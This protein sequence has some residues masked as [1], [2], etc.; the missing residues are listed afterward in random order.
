LNGVCPPD[1]SF[2]WAALGGQFDGFVGTSLSSPDFVGLLAL[3]IQSEGG[4]LGNENFDIYALAAAQ[5]NGSANE[6]YRQNIPGN[7]GVYKTAPGYNLVLGNGTVV[8]TN[9]VRG[10]SLPAAGIPQTP[11]NP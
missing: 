2:D 6:V 8:G 4:R 11:T 3:K 10:P 7:N 5:A 9:F 1:R